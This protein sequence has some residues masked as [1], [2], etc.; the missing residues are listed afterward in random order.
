M[1]R[2]DIDTTD[3]ELLTKLQEA[4]LEGIHASVRI[5]ASAADI[6]TLQT[7]AL[8]VV[9]VTKFIGLPLFLMWLYDHVKK[10]EGHKTTITHIETLY[11]IGEIRMMINKDINRDDNDISQK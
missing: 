2:L 5:Q 7:M 6:D 3:R 9:Q 11:N 1:F 8:I 10:K 4:N